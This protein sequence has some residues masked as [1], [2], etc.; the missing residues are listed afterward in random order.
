MHVLGLFGAVACVLS[1]RGQQFKIVVCW[2]PH[3]ESAGSPRASSLG[4]KETRWS[5]SI[6]SKFPSPPDRRK[7]RVIT[8][9][10]EI[11]KYRSVLAQVQVIAS[12]VQE[13]EFRNIM[14]RFVGEG[15]QLVAGQV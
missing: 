3:P 2:S 9:C 11:C 5:F 14:E 12:Q 10:G 7:C 15:F 6:N 4:M 8:Q 1:V 13:S